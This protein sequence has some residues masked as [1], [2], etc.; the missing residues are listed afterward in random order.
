MKIIL[1]SLGIL[2]I[3]FSCSNDDKAIDRVTQEISRG[4]ILRTIAIDNLEFDINNSNSVFSVAI[5]EQDIENG[6][7]LDYVDVF[8]SFED[9]TLEPGE[10]YS[11]PP[12]LIERLEKEDF[13]NG[14]R[15]LP[16][17]TLAY[18]FSQLLEETGVLQTNVSCKDQFVITLELQLL[19]GDRFTES[20]ANAVT[21]ASNT[22]SSSPFSYTVTVLE[23]IS[24]DLFIGD[25]AFNSVEE[26]AFGPSFIPF[27]PTVEITRGHSFNTRLVT[28]LYT[29]NRNDPRVFEFT[30]A[31]DEII[32]GKYQLSSICG[33]CNETAP[34]RRDCDTGDLILL[35]PDT[36][37]ATI[38][39]NDDTVFELNF[40][41]GYRGFDGNCGFDSFPSKIRFTKQ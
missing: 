39:Q 37:N 5:E 22:F 34:G 10:S 16:V 32:M 38:A 40:V 4:A 20:N 12:T 13:T 36:V 41:E 7:L 2:L 27:N 35:G 14:P 11:T 23:P 30:I 6:D 33:S 21:L 9:H 8:V 3:F 26:G 25:Y 1:P 18:S 28:L 29:I 15:G 24:E 17:R 19:N 31:C